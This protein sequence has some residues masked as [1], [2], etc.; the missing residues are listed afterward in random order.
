MKVCPLDEPD[1]ELLLEFV[2]L[3]EVRMRASERPAKQASRRT[4]DA[5]IVEIID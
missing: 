3:R 4:V 2:S 5:A 1:V